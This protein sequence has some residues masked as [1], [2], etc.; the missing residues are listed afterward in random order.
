M[1][2]LLFLLLLISFSAKAGDSISSDKE[3]LQQLLQER[4]DR[5]D[6]YMN[7]LQNKSGWFGGK[8]KKDLLHSQEILVE[9]VR[10]DNRMI[11][12][13]N[14]QIDYKNFEKTEMTYNS[15][16]DYAKQNQLM[17]ELTASRKNMA[18]LQR[19]Y[20]ESMQIIRVR[21]VIMVLSIMTALLAFILPWAWLRRKENLIRTEG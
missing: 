11:S 2:A 10:L 12:V 3:Q 20:T 9:I 13:L 6:K 4:K 14:R 16:D 15:L 7:S 8:T 1:R 21:T 18:D 5:F 17:N 19:R